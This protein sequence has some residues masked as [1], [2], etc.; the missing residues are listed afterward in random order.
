MALLHALSIIG[1]VGAFIGGGLHEGRLASHLQQKHP[2]VW[3]DLR[4]RKIMFVEGDMQT[5]AMQR[6]LWRGEHKNLQ[7]AKLNSMV[8]TGWLWAALFLGSAVTLIFVQDRVST[9]TYRACLGLL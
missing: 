8:F 2:E 6:Y 5:A 7:D 1:L 3:A 4:H 9:A